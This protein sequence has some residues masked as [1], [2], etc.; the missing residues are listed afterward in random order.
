MRRQVLMMK[1]IS[2]LTVYTQCTKVN[3]LDRLLNQSRLE[4][5]AQ[6]G[7][8]KETRYFHH[9][10]D[11]NKQD[12]QRKANIKKKYKVRFVKNGREPWSTGYG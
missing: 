12:K 2:M 1:S 8:G 5:I 10:R 11:A 3:K 7:M 6:T 4:H 9:S